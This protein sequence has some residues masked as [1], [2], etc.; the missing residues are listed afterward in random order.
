MQQKN[1]RRSN[2]IRTAETRSALITAARRLFAEKGFADTATPEISRAAEV[3]RG[4]LYHHFE[5]KKDVFR[6]VIQAEAE[7]VAREIAKTSPK[8]MEPLEVLITGGAAYYEAM[9][10]PGRARLM[11]IDGPAVLGYGEIREIDKITG[12]E[13]LRQGL[14]LLANHAPLD[15]PVAAVAD[16]LSAM[17]DRAALAM[18]TGENPELYKAAMEKILRGLKN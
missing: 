13:E 8:E 9:S 7:A 3:T 15:F 14:Q 5:D 18:E 10:V 17:F 2:V 11:L 6:A 4:A 12:G 1:K 16:L